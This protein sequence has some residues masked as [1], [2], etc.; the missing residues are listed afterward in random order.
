[1]DKFVSSLGIARQQDGARL[2]KLDGFNDIDLTV[3]DF[4][5]G[6]HTCRRSLLPEELQQE[7]RDARMRS[8]TTADPLAPGVRRDVDGTVLPP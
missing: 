8:G 2:D 6:F 3:K 4:L 7:Q 1:M 5:P